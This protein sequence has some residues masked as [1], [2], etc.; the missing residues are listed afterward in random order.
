MTHEFN[1]SL[2]VG[3][4]GERFLDGFFSKWYDIRPGKDS[5]RYDRVFARCDQEF[6]VEYKTDILAHTTNN[7]FIELVSVS[8]G[9]TVKEGWAVTSKADFVAYYVPGLSMIF[10]VHVVRLRAALP[11][12]KRLYKAA[13]ADNGSYN[14]M[15]LLV[16]LWSLGSIAEELNV[17]PNHSTT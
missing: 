8:R 13:S 15:G 4:E 5:E 11:E 17:G 6:K 2:T 12:W 3:K 1:T 14:S 10:W 7:A 9:A 16:P